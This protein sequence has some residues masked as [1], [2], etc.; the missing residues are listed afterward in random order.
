MDKIVISRRGA[1]KGGPSVRKVRP[2]SLRET[3]RARQVE[4][5][6]VSRI[7][8]ARQVG[9]NES[10]GEKSSEGTSTISPARGGG[11]VPATEFRAARARIKLSSRR[12]GARLMPSF[13]L[14]APP[15]FLSRRYRASYS[16]QTDMAGGIKLLRPP[17]STYLP[18]QIPSF[19]FRSKPQAERRFPES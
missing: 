16:Y 9:A 3:I 1:K 12:G 10:P 11:V 5:S 14:L 7:S 4:N 19:E 2:L 6:G 8:R 18:R 13:L 15:P 17:S